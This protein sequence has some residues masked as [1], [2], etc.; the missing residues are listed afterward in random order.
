MWAWIE[1]GEVVVV[2][3]KWELSSKLVLEDGVGRVV[4]FDYGTL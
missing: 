2:V 3:G 1:V 4:Y